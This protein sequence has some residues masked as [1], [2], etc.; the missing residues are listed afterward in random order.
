MKSKFEFPSLNPKA[1]EDEPEE[2]QVDYLDNNPY[3]VDPKFRFR[4]DPIRHK[5]NWRNIERINLNALRSGVSS[6]TFDEIN[7]IFK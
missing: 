3:I 6:T 5:I 1:L 7:T 2:G 4:F